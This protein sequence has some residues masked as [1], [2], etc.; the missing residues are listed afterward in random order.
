[1]AGLRLGL[2]VAPRDPR[3]LGYL[4]V[5]APLMLGLSLLTVDEWY[6][7]YFGQLL[8]SGSIARLAYARQLMQLPV[9]V[10]GPAVATAAPPALAWLASEGRLQ[11]LRSALEDTLRA[12]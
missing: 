4:A 8:P 1:A 7:R 2:R 9:A 6:D 3:F 11:D 10:V 5:A 12:A